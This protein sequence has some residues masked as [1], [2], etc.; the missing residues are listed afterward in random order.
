MFFVLFDYVTFA[1][2]GCQHKSFGQ[3]STVCVCNSNHCDT[4]DPIQKSN[5]GI[6]QQ[7]ST[8]K[9][10]DRF[11]R[12]ELH[13]EQSLSGGIEVNLYPDQKMQKIIGFGGA[14]TDTSG[15]NFNRLSHQLQEHLIRDYFGANGIEYSAVRVTIGGSDMSQREYSNDDSN[16]DDTE[17]HHF[18]LQQKEDLQYKIPFLKK[19]Q[20]TNH[21]MKLF[22]SAWSAPA[23]MKNN[24]DL[25]NG[26]HL[27]GQPG[28]KYHRAFAQYLVKFM[29]A[30]QQHNI[31]WWGLTVVN[32]PEM[33]GE[34]QKNFIKKDLG[35]EL[36]N[37][38]FKN[39]NLMIYDWNI[40]GMKQ[41]V[42]TILRDHDA[43]KY[44][45]GIAYHWYASNDQ[46]RH[47]LKAIHEEFPKYFVL[48][49]EACEGFGGDS[50][51]VWHTAENYA[52]DVIKSLKNYVTGWI[53]W[54]MIV[55]MHGGPSWINQH[56]N[57]PIIV[58]ADNHE[59]YKQPAFYV[60]G[61]FSKF[62][63]P[64]SVH[65]HLTTNSNHSD[66]DLIAFER[67][68]GGTVMIIFN[69]G[70]NEQK[71]LINDPRHG[72][73]HIHVRAHSIQSLIWY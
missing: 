6:I 18:A 52:N 7:F 60:L 29:K 41:F 51:G 35:P 73:S 23:W 69:K 63:P 15:Y 44:V 14:L 48:S 33:S 58:N 27:R 1:A 2:I 19:T 3:E 70:N 54:N 34:E 66:Y 65:I 30:Y 37:Q 11:A 55:D 5:P 53:D 38:G 21:H 12:K 32:E 28:D 36:E 31:S 9:N 39:F 42:E 56:L 8:S 45:K 49:T 16:D 64:N 43:A 72:K 61:H 59:Y 4:I 26:G 25:G 20:S 68:D 57:A 47:D 40:P 13:F 50:L 46:N 10:G 71:F 17:F 22:G 24:H 67:P 62:L